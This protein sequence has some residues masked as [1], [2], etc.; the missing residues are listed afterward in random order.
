MA[1]TPLTEEQK[2]IVL[3][4]WNKNPLLPPTLKELVVLVF[5][6][7]FDG[8]SD[9]GKI[10]KYF[11][12]QRQL[13]A[14]AASDD[15][16][17]TDKI[18]LTDEHKLYI[19]NNAAKNSGLEMARTIFNNASISNLHAETRVVNDFIKTLDTKSVYG[20]KEIVDEIPNGEY[21]PPKTL[22]KV[23]KKTNEYVNFVMGGVVALNG[24]QKKWME[25]LIE[26]LNTY[27]FI[28]LMNTYD[29]SYDR[30]TCEDAFVRYTYDKPDL[31]QEEIDQY[32]EL[33]NNIVNKYKIQK[34]LNQLR[35]QQSEIAGSDPD[36]QKYSMG[37]VE[38][39]GKASTEYHQNSD[40]QKKL[41]ESL[42]QK[43]SER[44][45][46]SI[47]DTATVLSLVHAWRN[48]ED[49][50]E[51]IKMAMKEQQI[52]GKEIE[53]IM[54]VSELKARIMGVNPEA[55]KNG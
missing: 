13:R 37:L 30:K 48:Y 24:K 5:G 35:K 7:G 53:R 2:Q 36:S 8:R 12:A 31:T 22:D 9:Y 29:S 49:R 54:D 1:L 34:H 19:V 23:L 33:S 21:E 51:M 26:Y 32:I 17:K 16:R 55:L 47:N 20:G 38:A 44:L 15:D 46:A 43:R 39:I 41:L 14:K 10:I 25:K 52:V 6:P 11:L 27:S 18:I 40:R 45:E 50:Q 42:T 28:R 4:A 3:D